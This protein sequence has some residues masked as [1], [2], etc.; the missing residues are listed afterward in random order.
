MV[1]P[2]G[3]CARASVLAGGSCPMRK[4]CKMKRQRSASGTARNHGFSRRNSGIN[5]S[6]D[7]MY[8]DLVVRHRDFRHGGDVGA[9]THLLGDTA[10]HAFWRGLVPADALGDGVQDTQM[11][12]VVRHQLATE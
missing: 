6:N 4:I 11:F 5:G 3:V 8:L 2:V 12:W 1:P 10:K 7:T 9:K